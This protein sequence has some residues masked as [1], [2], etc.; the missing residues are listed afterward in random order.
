VRR[1]VLNTAET[2]T[3]G[4][5]GYRVHRCSGSGPEVESPMETGLQSAGASSDGT[6]NEL[7]RVNEG[8]LSLIWTHRSTLA[9]DTCFRWKVPNDWWTLGPLRS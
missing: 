4:R 3:L 5:R 9:I 7:D 6:V 2:Q 1:R 8:L